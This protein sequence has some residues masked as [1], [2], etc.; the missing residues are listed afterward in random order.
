MDD[1]HP[2][3]FCSFSTAKDDRNIVLSEICIPEEKEKYLFLS[4][5]SEKMTTACVRSIVKKYVA[6]AQKKHPDLFGESGY[7]PHSFRHS[8]AVHLVEA[9]V[10][11]I[12]IRNFL[13]HEHIGTTEIYACVGQEAVTRA[14]T[15]RRIPRRRYLFKWYKFTLDKSRLRT[16]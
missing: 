4:Q 16:I 11:L 12:Y 15:N 7:S 2:K 14:L 10:D 8:K 6:L 1:E 3:I 9:G 5:A 13:G